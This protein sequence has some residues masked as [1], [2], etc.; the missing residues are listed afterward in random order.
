MSPKNPE[1]YPRRI[2]VVVTGKTPQ[3]VTETIYGLAVVGTPAFVPTEVKVVTTRPGAELATSALLDARDGWFHR[4]CADYG[5]P[6]IE[7]DATRIHILTDSSGAYLDDIREPAHNTAAADAIAQLLC[8]LTRDES[9]ALHVS[10][11]GGRKTM[12][13]FVGHALSLYGRRQDR[14]SHVLVAPPY[15]SQREFFY[16]TPTSSAIETAE[17][18]IDAC[19]GEVALAEIPFVRL[20]ESLPQ[21]L[22]EGKRPF[23]DA[24]DAAQ[25]AIGPVEL[26]IDLGTERVR[27]GGHIVHVPPRELAFLAW[28]ARRQ[29]NGMSWQPC[30]SKELRPEREYATG[31][32]CEYHAIKGPMGDCEDTEKRLS[33]GMDYGYF[34]EVKSRLN[35]V[36]KRELTKKI[37]IR[38]AAAYRVTRRKE[39]G[40]VHGLDVPAAS[41]HFGEIDP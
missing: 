15:E 39:H 1:T 9:T 17:G 36:L 20:R 3:V 41:I 28:L 40:W 13:F 38:A 29:Q 18:V 11:A 37:G 19:R 16:P 34:Q 21:D 2:L 30:P 25:R 23:H 12:G 22:L 31:F 6:P 32:L 5:L 14:L 24:V 33:D 4:L 26:V 10:I 35:S 8:E 27:A 7:F